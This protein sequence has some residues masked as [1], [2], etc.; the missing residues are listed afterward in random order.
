MQENTRRVS[1]LGVKSRGHKSHKDA[2]KY[3]N[4]LIFSFLSSIASPHGTTVLAVLQFAGFWHGLVYG[5]SWWGSGV[6]WGLGQG[7]ILS[8]LLGFWGAFWEVVV[9]CLVF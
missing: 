4:I 5:I 1:S 6:W 8:L 3:K 9:F 2:V 7:G